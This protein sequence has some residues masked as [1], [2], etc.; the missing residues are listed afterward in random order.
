MA[1]NKIKNQ[2]KIIHM[3]RC[4]IQE[5]LEILVFMETLYPFAII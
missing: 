1:L 2:I 4:N 3:N 5:P